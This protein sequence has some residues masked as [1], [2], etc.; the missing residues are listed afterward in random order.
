M[1]ADFGDIETTKAISNRRLAFV[2]KAAAINFKPSLFN[3]SD[4]IEDEPV[5]TSIIGTPVFDNLTFKPGTFI[6]RDGNEIEYNGIRVDTVLM[7]VSNKR[8]IV[9]TPIS[10][11]DNT[12]KEFINNGPYTIQVEGAIYN[13]DPNQV[14]VYPAVDVKAL[15]TLT[16]V[17]D[18][19][20]VV[21]KFLNQ[22][23]IKDVVV[24][25]PQFPTVPGMRGRQLFRMTLVTDD[26][27]E[28]LALRGEL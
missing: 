12:I 8:N 20:E 23:N 19:I 27:P 24:R 13:P 11:S 17:P 10:G 15:I 14:D 22:F 25:N 2:L 9:E 6:D 28:F 5:G 1:A 16:R 3:T 21:S 4:P 18:S 7:T 26:I